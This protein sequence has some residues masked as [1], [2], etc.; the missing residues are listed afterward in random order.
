MQ[1][2]EYHLSGLWLFLSFG[3]ERIT[4]PIWLY[5]WPWRKRPKYCGLYHIGT[6]K[7]TRSR[8]PKLLTASTRTHSILAP[9][10]G[11]FS[12][13]K[14]PKNR[15]FPKTSLLQLSSLGCLAEGAWEMMAGRR[16]QEGG[17]TVPCSTRASPAMRSWEPGG[18]PRTSVWGIVLQKLH[19]RDSHGDALK[20]L[21]MSILAS[22]ASRSKRAGP[23]SKLNSWGWR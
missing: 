10:E 15:W 4:V 9:L 23:H 1:H 20:H 21:Y 22:E 18:V 8:F 12:A 2:K 7:Y 19:C 3:N 17:S 11:T 16:Q 14:S 13:K 5:K 6:W